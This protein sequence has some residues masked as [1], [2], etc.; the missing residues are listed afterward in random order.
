VSRRR[1]AHYV[2]VAAAFGCAACSLLVDVGGLSGGPDVDAAPPADAQLDRATDARESGADA[3]SG[4]DADAAYDATLEADAPIDSEAA[5]DAA[6]LKISFVSRSLA[7]PLSNVTSLDLSTPAGV[8]SGD[9]ILVGLFTDVATTTATTPAGFTKLDDLPS[10]SDT[11]GWYYMRIAGGSEPSKT[12]FTFSSTPVASAIAVA[13]RNVR[14]VNPIDVASYGSSPGN[15]L[16]SAAVTT[17][18]ANTMLVVID[19]ADD[20][21]TANWF[22]PTGM[23]LRG[24]TGITA[25]FDAPFATPGSTGAQLATN[26]QNV[27]ALTSLIALAPK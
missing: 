3:D 10:G 9:V 6:P 14:A 8:V 23:T 11:H 17:T 2:A 18:V 27:G 12:T 15:P 25:A 26:D 5:A 20:S 16:T 7:A 4:V 13:Y 1:A 19:L 22:A 21:P 24:Q